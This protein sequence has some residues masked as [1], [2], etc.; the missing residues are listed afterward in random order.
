M[1]ARKVVGKFISMLF[2]LSI[3][4]LAGCVQETEKKPEISTPP[5][6][7]ITSPISPTPSTPELPE[8]ST[9]PSIITTPSIKEVGGT[10]YIGL[11]APL[12]GV[13]AQFGEEAYEGIRM[14]VEDINKAGGIVIGG[15]VYKFELIAMDD[16]NTP[17]LSVMN[18]EKMLDIYKTPVIFCPHAGGALALQKI[19]EQRG[20]I[21]ATLSN[22][23]RPLKSGNKMNI[24][25]AIPFEI[26]NVPRSGG[27]MLNA[28]FKNAVIM[29]GTHEYAVMWAETFSKWWTMNG[30]KILA[31]IPVNYYV[32]TDL[33]PHVMKA[34]AAKP[35]V[36]VLIGPSG[37]LAKV[38][39]LA[40][41]VGGY[42]GAFLI[43]EQARLEELM[44]LLGITE[45]DYVKRVAIKGDISILEK[46]V[47][48]PSPCQLA[49]FRP[50]LQYLV[51]LCALK[52]K[53]KRGELGFSHGIHYQTV[54]VIAKA[55]EITQ[56]TEP[57]KI[58]KAIEKEVWPMD[59]YMGVKEYFLK[60]F[61]IIEPYGTR[62]IIVYPN[63]TY[64]VVWDGVLRGITLEH[65]VKG[66]GT[67]RWW[68]VKYW[69]QEYK[70]VTGDGVVKYPY[71]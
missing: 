12:S 71:S 3:L 40:R 26:V 15:K 56:S 68:W 1:K 57:E 38:I 58:M 34:L 48:E 16:M 17:T 70:F 43:A 19:N 51:D 8:M 61:Y 22:D 5:S 10:I 54:M 50:D 6:T 32:E 59:G 2:V 23:P 33:S 46:T 4:L 24:L 44:H 55:M 21:L 63:P 14:A 13:A 47:G 49:A 65:E 36:I 69:G 62:G 29:P 60:D 67:E 66:Y 42:K 64:A 39:K 11:T 28:G 37:P 9:T 25:M 27:H 18:A 45:Y 30:G 35:D 52:P 20:F 31:R 7:E 41:E 53:L